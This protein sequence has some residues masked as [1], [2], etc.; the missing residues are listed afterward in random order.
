MSISI[1]KCKDLVRPIWGVWSASSLPLLPG[2]LLAEAIVPHGVQ[3]LGQIDLFKN[4]SYSKGILDVIKLRTN[5]LPFR[6][7][8]WR[9]NCLLRI[10]IIISHLKG[11]NCRL[12]VSRI[13][14]WRY[15]CLLRIIIIISYLKACNCRLFVSRIVTWRYNCLLRII[16]IISYLKGCNCKLFVLRIVTW[17]YNC[18]LEIIIICCISTI[19]SY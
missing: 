7:V 19:N 4:Y 17:R 2:S 11:C 15:N 16:I 9:Y 5:P 3:S 8:T 6:I 14:T 18:L 12:F 13:V 10:I 1:S